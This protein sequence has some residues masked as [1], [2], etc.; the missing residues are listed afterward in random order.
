M[1]QQDI[2]SADIKHFPDLIK[3]SSALI[4]PSI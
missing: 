2:R 1:Q 4:T 3:S